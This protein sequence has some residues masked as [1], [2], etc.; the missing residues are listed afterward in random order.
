MQYDVSMI[1]AVFFD[2][3]GTLYDRDAAIL[4]MAEEQFEAFSE[5]L[6]VDKRAFIERLVVLDGHG[7]NRIPRLH[8]ALA[9]ELGFGSDLAD[10]LEALFRSRYPDQCW[11]SQDSLSTLESLR[12]SRKKLGVITNGPTRWQSRKID[13]MG[14]ASVF[15]AVLIS[16]RE[17]IQK[18]DPRIFTRPSTAA[19]FLPVNRYLLAIIPKSISAAQRARG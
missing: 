18:P 13:C 14:I 1:R 4:R 12:A 17:G 16:E 8:H 6:G 19:A 5:Q 3:D 7:H 11:I 15:D 10:R 9:R 2:L